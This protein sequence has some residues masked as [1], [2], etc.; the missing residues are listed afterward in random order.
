MQLQVDVALNYDKKLTLKKDKLCLGNNR[1]YPIKGGNEDTFN[2]Q[3]FLAED[4]NKF[5]ETKR[6]T[7][8]IANKGGT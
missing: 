6:S 1:E 2:G 7:F 5:I 8:L 3:I 4:L